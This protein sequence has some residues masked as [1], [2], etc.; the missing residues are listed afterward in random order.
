MS[1]RPTDTRERILDTA[2][3]LFSS[4]GFAATSIDDILKA[5]GITK[6][7]FYHY[8]NSKEHLCQVILEQA[9][10]SFHRLADSMLEGPDPALSLR[11]WLEV[12][13]QKQRSGQW[14]YD[15]LLC[16]LTVEAAQLNPE[17]QNQLR[18]FWQWCQLFYESLIRK[19]IGEK[20]D[21]PKPSSS[22]RLLAAALF[23]AVWLDRCAG[24]DEE[25]GAIRQAL[26]ELIAAAQANPAKK[27]E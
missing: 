21:W 3:N 18:M 23:G 15:R 25:Q 16:R 11:Q 1:R 9:I 6:G 20:G 22:A 7:A 8:F 24:S 12:L 14:L 17:A 13:A 5:V 26:L 4:H 27:A 2:T 10:D 19:T